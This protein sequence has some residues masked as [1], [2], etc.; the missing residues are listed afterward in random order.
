[1]TWDSVWFF[2]VGPHDKHDL[3][4]LPIKPDCSEYSLPGEVSEETAVMMGKAK[5]FDDDFCSDG[6]QWVC[7][8]MTD[9]LHV[10]R[11][12]RFIRGDR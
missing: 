3:L 11:L 4:T 7:Y 9:E 12:N 1:M 10:I 2:R 6:N 8:K 5:A